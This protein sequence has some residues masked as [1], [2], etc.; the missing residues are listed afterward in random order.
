MALHS[1]MCGSISADPGIGEVG[2]GEE[3]VVPR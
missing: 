1:V 2:D 3:K